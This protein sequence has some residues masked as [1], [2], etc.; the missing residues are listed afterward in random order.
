M[1]RVCISCGKRVDKLKDGLCSFCVEAENSPIEEVKQINIK[2]CNFCKKIF[3]NNRYYLPEEFEE[4]LNKSIGRYVKVNENYDL[5]SVSVE[6]F[7]YERGKI[8][9]DVDVDASLKR[10][11]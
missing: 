3:F 8:F 6:N 5:I 2:Y 10:I 7:V 4:V 1:L 11:E 9:F